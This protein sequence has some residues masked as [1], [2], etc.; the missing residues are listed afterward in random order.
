MGSRCCPRMLSC[1]I[2]RQA[3]TLLP[4]AIMLFGSALW[5]Q[6]VQ[7]TLDSVNSAT[8]EAAGWARDPT[9]P[10]PIQVSLYRD[11][12]NTSGTL[13]ATFVASLLRTDLPYPDQDHGFDQIFATN[14]LL[15][16][17][18]SHTI[19]AYGITAAGAT[20][21]LNGNG[22]TIQC[23]SIGTQTSTNVMDYGAN[24][25]G[26]TDDSDA[27]QAAID[28][29]LP[30]GTVLIPSG[31]YMLG[32]GHYTLN[33]GQ[34][35]DGVSSEQYA[36]RLWKDVT[37]EGEGR[38]SILKLMPV[39]LGI[40]FY[41]A[42]NI[43]VQKLVFD[44]NG[45]QRLQINPATG[46]SYGWPRGL[47]VSALWAG[48]DQNAGQKIFSDSEFRYGL[49]DGVGGLPAPGLTVQG[50]YIH[51][52][53]ASAF[54]PAA[55]STGGG[56]AIS[57]DG[58]SDQAATDNIVVGNT[59][60]PVVGFGTVG[61]NI[62]YNVTLGNCGPGI[63]LGGV[64]EENPPS[65]PDS[66]FAVSHNWVERNGTAC[67]Q[68]GL[69]IWG[70]QNGTITDNY[71]WSNVSYTGILFADKGAGW[72]ASINWSVQ[73]NSIQYNQSTG[74]DITLRS[75]GITLDNNQL[76]NNGSSLSSQVYIDPSILS[77][78]NANWQSANTLSYTPPPSNPATPAIAS[79]VNAASEQKGGIS[80][81]EV[82]VIYGSNLGP[83]ILASAAPNSDGR[84]ERIL[85]N[86]RV[87]FDGVPGAMLYTSAGQV[88]LIAPY[89]LYWKDS[90]NVQ[91]EY[92]GVKSSSVTVAIQQSQPA[93]FS[94]NSSGSGPGAIL[95]QDYS[96]NSASNPAARA[97][98]V[99]LYATGEGQTDPA[100][101]D[102]LTANTTLPQPRLPVSVTIAGINANVLYAGAAPTFVAGA[103]QVN[104]E[105]PSNA[106]P[107]SSV[108]VQLT[109]GGV[110]SP[111]GV[112]VSLR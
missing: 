9:N 5:A 91:V 61:A 78:V 100:G 93:I 37:L 94:Q 46:I 95:N 90:T 50:C 89:Y 17:G 12:D 105:V 15:A 96:I 65:R 22:K 68:P 110:S 13:I 83:S 52:N 107:G 59:F 55:Q 98:V 29:T 41:L 32:T 18:K 20:G 85:A 84:Y 69:L 82:L 75:S 108:P 103:L 28:D 35:I 54:E 51:E 3:A 97:S 44:G 56:A 39:R 38:T 2:A 10:N 112:T 64:A 92:N 102:G 24:G 30:G 67:I 104:V 31:T 73:N 77:G 26:V 36:L 66:G 42:D 53:G 11:G 60:G 45:A 25:N 47:I 109:I 16:D 33:Y 7:G 1:L 34:T 101:T 62:S 48:S 40:G 79:V 43:L 49:E 70:G 27:I 86:T 99:I 111:A 81:G 106:P 14:P 8:C 71:I 87:L 80:P 23:A 19:Y 74:V 63:A 6:V 57:L 58:Q 21:P 72:P 4:I 76:S 88:A